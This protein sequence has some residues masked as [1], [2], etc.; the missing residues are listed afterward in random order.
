MG[1]L[2][3][4]HRVYMKG[5]ERARKRPYTLLRKSKKS[6][7]KTRQPIAPKEGRHSGLPKEAQKRTGSQSNTRPPNLRSVSG[8]NVRAASS[9]AKS[10]GA[11]RKRGPGGWRSQSEELLGPPPVVATVSTHTT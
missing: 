5:N 8:G 9:V 11:E 2:G 10:G 7:E 4:F 3:L 1:C 6:G